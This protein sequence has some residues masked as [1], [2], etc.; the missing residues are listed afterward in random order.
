M[1]SSTLVSGRNVSP[2]RFTFFLACVFLACLAFSLHP[3]AGTARANLQGTDGLA[4][5][6]SPEILPQGGWSVGLF[7][8][9]Y[10]RMSPTA[11]S[12]TEHFAVGDL[13]LRYGLAE[14][15]EAFAVLPGNGTLW[16]YK[17][18]PDRDEQSVNHGGVG[19]ARLGLKMKLPL[20]S[21]VF[22]LGFEAGASLPTGNDMV[23][24]LPGNA[25]G[26]KLFTSGSTNLFARLC[27]SVDLS[28][29]R[30]LSP[31]KLIAN[32][33]YQINGEEGGARFP[34]YLFSIPGSL[35]NNDVVSGG[36][37][38]VFPSSRVTLFTELYTEQFVQGSGV[39]GRKESPVF[40]TPGAKVKLPF[41]LV[42]TAAVDIRL[43]VDDRNTVFN[44]DE[45]FPEWGITL[46]LDFTPA[47]FG[48][49]ADGDG[50]PD[51]QDLC[52]TER[53]D[54][55]GFQDE[56]GCPDPDNDND[57]VPDLVDK[58]P[59]QPEDLDGFQDSDGCPD[60]D[61]DR[62]GIVDSLDRCPDQPGSTANGGCPD[63]IGEV[64]PEQPVQ[65]AEMK[66]APAKEVDSDNDGVPDSRDKCPTLAEDRDGF[67]DD[68]GCPD[69]DNDA[70][71][72]ID[73]DDK[74]PN[75]PG[76]ESNGGCPK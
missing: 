19:D 27:A 15:L 33:G 5:L 17:E 66:P 3:F 41:D 13:S 43:S 36:L 7:G 69:I 18:L 45:A 22:S 46:G 24:W 64:K 6:S 57:G 75:Q 55:D 12:V 67:Q 68:D 34:S 23:L 4:R 16:Q 32:A 30:A 70:D 54:F 76:P 52:P 29:V 35:D 2:K 74:C 37:A 50:I 59:N 48:N 28:Q 71:G 38:L 47:V 51:A 39:A 26:E 31:L 56:D 1:K 58:C 42:A 73:A 11:H 8:N 62:D 49:D 60:F 61:N 53:E 63:S 9:Y 10:R 20:E 25:T 72:I 44:P 40:L 21:D 14:V 65:P